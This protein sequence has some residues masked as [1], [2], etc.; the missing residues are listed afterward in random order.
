MTPACLYSR[1]WLKMDY[2]V[3][4]WEDWKRIWKTLLQFLSL[5]L[6]ELLEGCCQCEL[7]GMRTPKRI[8]KYNI[9]R[10]RM[11]SSA[12]LPHSPEKKM[13]WWL[14]EMIIILRSIE[15]D[16]DLIILILRS[17]ISRIEYLSIIFTISSNDT[18]DTSNDNMDN[19]D[20][21]NNIDNVKWGQQHWQHLL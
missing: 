17:D 19:I 5:H 18:N 11:L 15:I 9:Q 4:L 14:P 7:W 6:R 13:I 16:K 3:A 21:N 10:R 20:N 1:F 2:L 8:R 12:I